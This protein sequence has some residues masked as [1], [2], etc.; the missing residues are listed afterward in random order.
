MVTDNNS[1]EIIGAKQ[2]SIKKTDDNMI[3]SETKT[4][5]YWLS[6]IKECLAIIYPIPIV[7]ILFTKI[8][9]ACTCASGSMEPALKVGTTTFYNRLAYIRHDIERGDIIAFKSDEFGLIFAKR[10]IGIPGDEISFENGYVVVNGLL[11][12]EPDYISEDIET[13]CEKSFVV[14][15][16]TVFVLGDNREDSY[17]SR[18]WKNPYIPEDRILGKYIGAIP[19]SVEYNL[20]RPIRG[21]ISLIYQSLF[22]PAQTP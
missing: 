14:P 11:A 18:F 21:L 16:G 19:F 1:L 3:K 12:D 2:L 10:V 13:N 5:S 17:D 15:E 7:L 8:I 6:K 4:L 22:N 9:F 20:L